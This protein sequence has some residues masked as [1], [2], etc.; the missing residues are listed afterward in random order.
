MS[1]RTLFRSAAAVGATVAAL[2]GTALPAHAA[3]V[4]ASFDPDVGPA[5]PGVG[6]RGTA[7]FFINDACLALTGFISN[8]NTCSDN[9]MAVTTATVELYDSSNT[10]NVLAT[11]TYPGSS[12]IVDSATVFLGEVTGF[13]TNFADPGLVLELNN[14]VGTVAL[15]FTADSDGEQ[16]GARLLLCP[17]GADCVPSNLAT[18]ITYT[19]RSSVPEPGTMALLA[20]AALGAAGAAR[21][22]A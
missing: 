19:T 14:F 10:S 16:G 2:F 6:F 11:L 12:F 18:D 17:R 22:R 21:R 3:V 20:L 4:V 1:I 9:T 7:E 8:A 5:L 15:S 13:N